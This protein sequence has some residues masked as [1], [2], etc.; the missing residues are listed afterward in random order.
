MGRLM[1]REGMEAV[2]GNDVFACATYDAQALPLAGKRVLVVDDDP[3]ILGV[4]SKILLE[5]GYDVISRRNGMEG[6]E[7]YR[8]RPCE[9]VLTDL[10]MPGM[11]GV[12]LARHIKSEFPLV[13]VVL[14][15][16]NLL[17]ERELSPDVGKSFVDEIL[18]KP[19]RFT[20][21]HATLQRLL[22]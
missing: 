7:T 11:D 16:G 13:P 15:T 18:Y 19:F 17:T 1:V 9:L 20:E 12:A 6:L 21:L 8:K 2:S 22:P 3:D 4:I 5:F 14:M 10:D